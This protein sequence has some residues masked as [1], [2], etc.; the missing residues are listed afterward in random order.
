MS[1]FCENCGA[2]INEN[3]TVCPNCNTPVGTENVAEKAE[4]KVEETVKTETASTGK[5]PDTKTIA[6]IGG[7][8]AAAVLAIIVIV[9][10]IVSG[11]YKAP[12]KKYYKGLNKCDA[13]SYAAAFPD[14]MKI[15]DSITDSKLKD[16]KKDEEKE[17][18]DNVKYSYKILKK[19]K[20]EKKDLENVQDYIKTRYKESVKVTKGFKVK[21]K[22][23]IKG[24]DDYDY[25]T[26]TKYVYKIDGKWYL[27]TVSPE[28]AQS[29]KK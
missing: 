2:E 28:T 24:K 6:I 16:Q 12:L 29:Y 17:Y 3:D 27:L 19:T 20:I 15:G 4:V 9:V 26:S 18:G 10:S 8:I 22:E 1:K 11:F 5:K 25:A 7:G 13:D 14:F 21:V 23:S